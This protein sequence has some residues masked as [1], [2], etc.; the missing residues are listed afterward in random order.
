MRKI[1]WLMVMSLMALPAW[2]KGNNTTPASRKGN[3]TAGATP[4][5]AAVDVFVPHAKGSPY[6]SIRIPCIVNADGT[7]IAVAEGRHDKKDQANNDIIASVSKNGGKTWSSPTVAAKADDGTCLNNPC[8]IYDTVTKQ[9]VL[10]FQRYPEGMKESGIKALDPDD[11]EALRNYVCFTKNGKTWTKPV[12]VTRTTRHEDCR[13]SCSGPNPGVML[14]RGEHKGRLVVAF[15]EA[16]NFGNWHITAAYS[17]DHGATWQMGEGRSA[18]GHGINEVS[19]VETEDG[20]V[21]VIARDQSG[22][23]LKCVA[24]SHDGGDT[25]SD[26][27]HH[28]ELTCTVCQNGLTRYSFSTDAKYGSKSRILFSG[29]TGKVNTRN[30][31]VIKMSYDDGETWPV[32]KSVGDG[33]FAYSVMCPLKPGYVAL[34]FEA[35][36]EGGIK[37]TPISLKWLTDGEDTGLAGGSSK[38]K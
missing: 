30:A 27:I 19:S 20:G 28:P 29:P 34:L 37:F 36:N 21:L 1:A 9:T 10:M 22:G 35:G 17:D 18:K 8:L 25:W 33:P 24:R 23:G 16:V 26:V 38:K 12:E 11:P 31:G 6:K 7:L 32:E 13:T 15:N 3:N 4:Y 14:T 5:E 2:G